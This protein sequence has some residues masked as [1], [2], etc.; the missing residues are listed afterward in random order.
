MLHD[1]KLE[2]QRYAAGRPR[3]A[4]TVHVEEYLQ[5]AAFERLRAEIHDRSARLL[6]A[7][8]EHLARDVERLP[9]RRGRRL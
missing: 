4:M 5:V 2:H 7:V 1:L 6:L 8:A 9:R 3:N